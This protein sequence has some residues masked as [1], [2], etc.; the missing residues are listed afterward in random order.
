MTT[1]FEIYWRK[2]LRT[3]NEAFKDFPADKKFADENFVDFFGK[4]WL[5]NHPNAFSLDSVLRPFYG[6]RACHLTLIQI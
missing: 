2:F 3:G 1:N 4:T 6:K 5:P